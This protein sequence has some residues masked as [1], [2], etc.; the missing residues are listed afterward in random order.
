MKPEIR[1]TAKDC[2][3]E[4]VEKENFDFAENM[5]EAVHLMSVK[6]AAQHALDILLAVLKENAELVE[7]VID[8][9]EVEMREND[10][11]WEDFALVHS[12]LNAAA[13]RLNELNIR[14]E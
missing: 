14:G 8:A 9:L 2:I 7:D 4:S 5:V 12:G 10:P 3:S 11:E 1:T 6:E 13:M